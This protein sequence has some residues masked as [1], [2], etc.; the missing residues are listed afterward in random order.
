MPT[1][2]ASSGPFSRDHHKDEPGD[3]G[4]EKTHRKKRGIE[5]KVKTEREKLTSASS[6]SNS[7]QFQI[8]VEAASP[9]CKTS[10]VVFLLVVLLPLHELNWF[11]ILRIQKELS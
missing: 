9:E 11:L 3:E 6:T 4:K 10:F 5:W 2:L 7:S 1:R 8:Q